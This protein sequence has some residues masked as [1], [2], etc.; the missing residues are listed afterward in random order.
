VI[1]A[2]AGPP[3]VALVYA[4]DAHEE[5]V[6]PDPTPAPGMPSGL[7]GRQVAGRGF[8]DA[9]ITHASP[10]ELVAIVRDPKA[11][12]ALAKII[13]D[14][15]SIKTRPRRFRV[16]DDRR[17]DES[18]RVGAP[19]EVVH[20]P[21]PIESRYAWARR[22]TNPGSFA[23][24]GV[25][26]TLA[27]LGA[28]G[29]IRDLITAPFEPYD[30]L[31][32]TSRAVVAMV[33]AVADAYGDY[34]RERHG[35]E[36]R[37]VPRLETIPLGVD[38]SAYRPPTP[39]ER[40]ARRAA[41][42]IGDDEVA[43]LFV[44]RL[45]HHA[46]AHP[47]PLFD[48]ARR[49]SRLTGKATHL[50]LSGWF[51]N[52]AVRDAF[53]GGARV[54]AP[55][56][57]VSFVDGTDPANRLGVWHAADIFCSLVDNIQE[58]F[59]LAVIEAMA[60]G[61]P[62]VASD[63]DGYRDLV[64]DGVTGRLVATS[65]L[66]GATSE[67]TVRLLRGEVTYDQ[68]LAESSQAVAVDP[69]D[70]ARCLAD[71]IADPAQRR[72]MG[73][74]GRARVLERFTW[75]GVVASYEALWSDLDAHRRAIAPAPPR[76]PALYPPPERSFAAYPTRW[77]SDSDRLIAAVDEANHT[78]D[79]LL[80]MPLTNHVPDHRATDPTSLRAVLDAA[81]PGATVSALVDILASSATD[82]RQA[83]A[84]IAWLIKYG[85]L[86]IEVGPVPVAQDRP[87]TGDC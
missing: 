33:R 49:A 61:L 79:Q 84:T 81:R 38:E 5:V 30:T 44:G 42:G 77:L 15:P 41:L 25:T 43:L 36:P 55:G 76:P 45:A 68:F 54:F 59:G 62:V 73:E 69:V 31:I 82:P 78:L 50:I 9:Y 16:I 70:A 39:D 53:V 14:H 27:S 19:A 66:V 20:L 48:A 65:M 7:M 18:L 40:R 67:T 32:C 6:R 47:F 52:R 37:I 10:D 63:W 51:V 28:V 1:G 2:T 85:L 11:T 64:A 22:G 3:R 86:R 80:G 72:R 12:D 23:I 35:G 29:L 74:A 87:P 24:T 21:T 8:L 34:L 75:R 83:R 13:R 60:C 46:K 57:R 4:A 17:F 71:L 56:I 26:H 58:T